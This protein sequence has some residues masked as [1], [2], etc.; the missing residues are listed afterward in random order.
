M[1]VNALTDLDQLVRL[2]AIKQLQ[3][4]IECLYMNV[5]PAVLPTTV[6]CH[7]QTRSR[8]VHYRVVVHKSVTQVEI[9][10]V[11]VRPYGY[12]I[13]QYEYS[14]D[15]M[16]SV[17]R[18]NMHTTTQHSNRYCRRTPRGGTTT[19]DLVTEI[20]HERLIAT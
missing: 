11:R 1:N 19:R 15:I 17:L 7:T 10:S 3:C 8:P 13:D 4:T 18:G 9:L 16:G 5:C 14:R 12:V 20:P 2:V 6:N